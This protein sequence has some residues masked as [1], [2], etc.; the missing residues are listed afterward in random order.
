MAARPACSIADPG[1]MGFVSKLGLA[2]LRAAPQDSR[3]GPDSSKVELHPAAASAAVEL[4]RS[5]P[6]KAA[7]LA[8]QQS[9]EHVAPVLPGGR[10]RESSS[11]PGDRAEARAM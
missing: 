10:Y 9:A 5:E 2:A 8:V 4:D 7:R 3:L 6:A 1:D 11:V